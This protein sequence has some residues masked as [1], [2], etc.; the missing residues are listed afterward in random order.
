MGTKHVR[1]HFYSGNYH[2]IQNYYA[3]GMNNSD[4]RNFKAKRTKLKW[5][6]VKGKVGNFQLNYLQEHGLTSFISFCI[7]YPSNP[8]LELFVSLFTGSLRVCL[9]TQPS[10]SK[11]LPK[12]F[13]KKNKKSQKN[14]E[15][16]ETFH[17]R[18]QPF[19]S[20]PLLLRE[21]EGPEKNISIVKSCAFH[22]I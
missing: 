9:P 21:G 12:V 14:Y 10:F 15:N 17:S 7:M 3:P 19:A 4:P 2:I 16:P 8:L 13:L 1:K 22:S 6:E 11:C 20:I 18:E 5:N